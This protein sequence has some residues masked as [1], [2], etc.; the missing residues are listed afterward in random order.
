MVTEIQG[1]EKKIF[2]DDPK[3]LKAVNPGPKFFSE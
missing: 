1:I 3:F 2:E